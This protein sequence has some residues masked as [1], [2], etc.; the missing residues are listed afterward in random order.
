MKTAKRNERN[1]TNIVE[2]G[3]IRILPLLV[4]MLF[5]FSLVSCGKKEVITENTINVYFVNKSETGI[6]S[7]P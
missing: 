2:R 7:K 6:V 5:C 1:F 3:W 4:V